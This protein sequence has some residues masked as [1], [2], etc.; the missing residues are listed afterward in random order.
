MNSKKKN[1]AKIIVIGMG[2]VGEEAQR[3]AEKLIE[4]GEIII[5]DSIEELSKNTG[6]DIKDLPEEVKIKS[7]VF[8]REPIPIR[9]YRLNELI[10][11]DLLRE[12]NPWPS[13][14]GRNGKKKW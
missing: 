12:N 8:D 13:P 11:V 9:N 4:A 5:I 10:N 3:I 6:I 14:K 2:L 7:T 1:K